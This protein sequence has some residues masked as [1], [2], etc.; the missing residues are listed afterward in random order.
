MAGMKGLPLV[1]VL[2]LLKSEPAK[3]SCYVALAVLSGCRVSELLALRRRD[4]IDAAGNLRERVTFVKLKARSGVRSRKLFIP[5]IFRPYIIAHLNA[6]A[7]RGYLEPEDFVFRGQLGR[8][9]SRFTVYNHFR[10]LLG[11]GFGTH[12]PRKTFAQEMFHY[13]LQQN[14]ADPLRA[15]ELTRRALGHARIDTTVRYLGIDET[16]IEEAQNEIFNHGMA[17]K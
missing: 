17:E 3:W 15:L 1:D 12:W 7:E 14:S 16:A 10:T 5:E 8:E 11:A 6:E 13:F 4:L 9:L 2:R